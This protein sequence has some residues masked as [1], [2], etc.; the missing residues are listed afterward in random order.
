MIIFQSDNGAEGATYEAL[1]T[2]GADLMRVINT[3][4]EWAQSPT[5]SSRSLVN[6]L[7]NNELENIGNHDS[8]AW[9]GTRVSTL[10]EITSVAS[11]LTHFPQHAVGPSL[12]SSFTII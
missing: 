11:Q 4:C 1:P 5:V 10:S 12:Y 2:M 7:D 6:G 3:Y 9:Y 8:F